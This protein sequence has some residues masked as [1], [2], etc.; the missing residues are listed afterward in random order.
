MLSHLGGDSGKK[1]IDE[2]LAYF[3]RGCVN[4]QLRLS[5]DFLQ[6]VHPD[7][8]SEHIEYYGVDIW[9]YSKRPELEIVK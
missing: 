6:K 4:S 7:T 8:C 3:K 2:N 5:F 9:G 1:C